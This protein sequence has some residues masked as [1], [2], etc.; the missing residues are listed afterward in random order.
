MV[1]Y[2]HLALRWLHIVFGVFWIGAVAFSVLVLRVV[3]PRA[4][5]E[6]R[7]EVLK[8]LIPV[9]LRYV[10]LTAIM[11]ILF[12]TLLYLYIGRFDAAELV[13]TLWGQIL[14]A[15]LI[16]TLGT[17]AFGM[18][19][20]FRASKALLGHLK[21]EACT[22]QPEVGKLQR[23][24][25]LSQITLLVLGAIIIALMVAAVEVGLLG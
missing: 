4:G 20:G 7:K 17:F 10:P 5:M 16:L 13:G 6:A 9:V 15:A 21:E 1:D 23:V 25:N 22:H 3:F 11:T 14:F 8:H 2:I 12:G 19:T 18:L 24:F